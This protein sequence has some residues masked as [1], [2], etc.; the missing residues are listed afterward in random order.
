MTK[1]LL[2]VAFL[3]LTA[4]ASGLKPDPVPGAMDSGYPT[5][6]LLACGKRFV[7]LGICTIEQGKSM[8]SLN[9]SI[10]GYYKGTIQIDSE[11]C[12]IHETYRYDNSEVVRAPLSGTAKDCAIDFV[13]AP[14]Y[15]KEQNS[16]LVIE[17][18]K[19]RVWIRTLPKGA[20]HFGQST[21]IKQAINST[22]NI[23][24][25]EKARVVFKGCKTTF[26]KELTPVDGVIKIKLHDLRNMYQVENCIFEGAVMSASKTLRVTW[27]VWSYD[28][29][30]TP[31][32]KP[33][34]T[35]SGK[36]LTVKADP[37][38]SIIALDNKFEIT[39]ETTFNSDPAKA[40]ILRM[41]TVGGRIVIG[42]WNG[43]WTWKN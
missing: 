35:W 7:G 9:V 36:K 15:P 40:H 29:G 14:E 23:P 38:V 17:S 19:G 41:A 31:L 18:I 24:F 13:L 12:D 16:G 39:N 5:A 42:E 3:W 1:L 33:V 21:K 43:A 10:Q 25:N 27:Q 2:A 30:F 20:A 8:S 26:D 32:A 34:A 4:C 22:L 6:E 37:A 11:E 28:D